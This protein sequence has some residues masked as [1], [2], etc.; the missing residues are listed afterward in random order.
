MPGGRQD[1]VC[2]IAGGTGQVISFKQA[3]GLGVADDRFDGI[4]S[5]Q[6]AFDR[7]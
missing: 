2:G 6:L 5:P 3:I 1:G 4:S 7:G